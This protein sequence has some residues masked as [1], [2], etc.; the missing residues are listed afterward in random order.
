MAWEGDTREKIVKIRG[1]SSKKVYE[2]CNLGF[3]PLFKASQICYSI[4]G[5]MAEWSIA[6]VLKT[7]GL[8]APGV[9]I[10]FPPLPRWWGLPCALVLIFALVIRMPGSCFCASTIFS[11][12]NVY[13]VLTM[14]V[15]GV[16]LSENE[17]ALCI[18]TTKK[19]Y[20]GLLQRCMDCGDSSKAVSQELFLRWTVIY[21]VTHR[22]VRAG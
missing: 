22:N 18:R 16:L 21:C 6:A 10:P 3:V 11:T 9:R 19:A 13:D 14:S 12:K 1:K 5:G 8:T 2:F 17:G 7:A 15:N 4:N 20:C